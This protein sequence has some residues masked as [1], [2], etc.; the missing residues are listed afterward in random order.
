ELRESIAEHNRRYHELD[1]PTISDADYD[2]LVRELRA[3]EEEF[4][5][6]ITP[7]SPTQQVG[8]RASTTFAPV[9]HRVPMMSLDN[10]FSED[11]LTAWGDR[12]QR[13]LDE[14]DGAVAVGYC[15][16]PKIDG[17]AISLRYEQGRFV[18]AAT[19]GDGKVGEDVT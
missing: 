2:D 10:A 5:E 17:L 13:R 14:G 8:A 7:D 6:L 9:E 3:I 16:E 15:C 18:Q 12:L 19:R 4:P 1:D 11:E